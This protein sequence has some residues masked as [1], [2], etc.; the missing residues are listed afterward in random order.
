M[1]DGGI[2]GDRFGEARRIAVGEKVYLTRTQHINPG[3]LVTVDGGYSNERAVV[4]WIVP[5]GA[6][7]PRLRHA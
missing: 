2:R 7:P 4:L 3:R 6:P 1:I 5:A